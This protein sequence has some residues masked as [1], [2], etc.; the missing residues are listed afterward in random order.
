MN[1][2]APNISLTAF[3]CQAQE[4]LK[5]SKVLIIGSGALG[6]T[7]AMYMAGSGVGTIRIVDFDTI[8]LSNLQRQVFFREAEC[9]NRKVKSLA[10]SISG[11]NSEIIVEEYDEMFNKTN[12]L[13]LVEGV[14]LVIDAADNPGTTYLI[15]EI[16]NKVEVPYITAGVTGWKAQI[17]THIPGDVNFSELFPALVDDSNPLPCS[18]AGV[19]GP[20][21]GIVASLEASEAIK[22]L[23]D[24]GS[25]L[26]NKLLTIDIL[27]NKF[28]IFPLS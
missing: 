19:F 10:N 20:L 23:T 1:R 18:V 9:G 27:N 16:A 22:V 24:V 2:Y 14:D 8:D 13:R 15:E 12:A 17:F 11:L 25:V 5:D 6:A 26:A 7:C 4:K 3:G 28:E 21:T